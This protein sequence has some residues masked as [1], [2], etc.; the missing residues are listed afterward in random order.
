MTRTYSHLYRVL[1]ISSSESGKTNV[2]LKL[3][4]HQQPDAD[5]IYLFVKDPFESKNQL[6]IMEVKKEGINMKKVKGA[7]WL[8]TSN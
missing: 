1:I 2:L 3:I 8:F 6:L 5:K 7:Y 4:N